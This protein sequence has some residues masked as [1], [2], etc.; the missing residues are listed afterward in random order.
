MG[1]SGAQKYPSAHS[2]RTVSGS[3]GGAA[4]TAEGELVV[5]GVHG[6]A[7]EALRGE[8]RQLT[9]ELPQGSGDRDA[10][11]ALTAGEQVDDP[12]AEVHS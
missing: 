5:G 2:V 3:D 7:V 9:G 6:T 1:S 10:E 12:S 4:A 11:D 8:L